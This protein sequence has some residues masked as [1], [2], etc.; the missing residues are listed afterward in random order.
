VLDALAAA[1][2]AWAQTAKGH[3]L[4]RQLD[5]AEAATWWFR[6]AARGDRLACANLSRAF[7]A[8]EGVPASPL[9][10]FGY[11]CAAADMEP[12]L[13][14]P[15]YPGRATLPPDASNRVEPWVAAWQAHVRAAADR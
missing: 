2:E 10:A 7:A 11:W 8:G 5:A 4:A 12:A 3:R 6:A 15:R 9:L 13:A 1:G 14:L